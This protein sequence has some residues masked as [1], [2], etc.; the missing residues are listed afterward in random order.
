[1]PRAS[2]VPFDEIAEKAGGEEAV[3]VAVYFRVEGDAPGNLFFLMSLASSERLLAEL[4]GQKRESGEPFSELEISALSEIANILVG[5]YLSS[6]AD[7]TQLAFL[8]TIPGFAVDMAGAILSIGLLQFGAMGDHA[9]LIETT[10]F[11]DNEEVGGNLFLIPDPDSFHT[12]FASL[13]VPLP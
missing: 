6:L 12:I 9:L 7:F 8:P 1:V 5:S 10:F 4:T 13:G 2:L 3:V 11:E